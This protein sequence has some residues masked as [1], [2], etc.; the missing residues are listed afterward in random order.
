[1]K[2]SIFLMWR[3]ILGSNVWKVVGLTHLFGV[4]TEVK[5]TGRQT[6]ASE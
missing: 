5:D 2:P 1:M 6:A 3:K 4:N